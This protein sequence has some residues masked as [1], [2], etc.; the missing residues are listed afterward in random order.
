VLIGALLC[1]A[2]VRFF[3]VSFAEFPE[4]LW[5]LALIPYV[6]ASLI[7]CLAGLRNPSGAYIMI[8]SVIPA[9]LMGQ[10]NLL[11][12]TPVARRLRRAAPPPQAIS[13]SPTAIIIALAFVMI[14]I[15]TAPGVRFT[16]R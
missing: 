9:A 13:A 5:R 2:T 4:S 6:A 15:L 14:I 12:V 1:G 8:V 3:A 11:L 7:F 16:L 10:A